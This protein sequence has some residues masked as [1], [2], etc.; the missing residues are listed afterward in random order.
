MKKLFGSWSNQKGYPVLKVTRN[1]NDGSV[2][3]YQQKYNAKYKPTDPIDP[4]MWW[5]PYNFASATNPASNVTGPMGWLSNT[6]REKH[7][8]SNNNHV[9][10]TNDDWL[11]FNIQ[12]TGY[13]RVWYD[14]ENYNLL[15][16]ELNDGDLNRIHPINR[17]Q[18]LDD[19]NDLVYSGRVSEKILCD[20]MSYLRRETSS[21]AWESARAVI[22][23]LHYNLQ[24]SK[25][26]NN[27]RNVVA[28]LVEP[29]Y[30]NKTLNEFDGD[31][32]FD[33][34]LRDT[35]IT[36]ACDFGVRQCLE[37]T[38]ALFQN[39]INGVKISQHIR[40]SVIAGGIRSAND[41]EIAKLWE[42]LLKLPSGGEERLEIVSAFSKIQN[43]STLEHYFNQSKEG[44]SNSTI[45]QMEFL[46]LSTSLMKINK[47]TV[48]FLIQSLSKDLDNIKTIF[49]S[50]LDIF[51]W[52]ASSIYTKD[53]E[54][55]VRI[56]IY[57]L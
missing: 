10:W 29:I 34:L 14:E 43:V 48:T 46:S 50:A 41:E 7:I 47:D 19:L 30:R 24:S 13:Y 56:R 27:F 52:I 37:D 11:L 23:S 9:K 28:N 25:K 4:T 12:Q 39:Y 22:T 26:L 18:I 38:Y 20:T 8:E 53:V 6:E 17:A 21:V 49:G 35:A 42:H 32:L 57:Q 51:E 15:S 1:Y 5:I 2:T 55:Q 45:S 3:L 16:K 33:R 31:G 36:L 40:R 54:T 44:L